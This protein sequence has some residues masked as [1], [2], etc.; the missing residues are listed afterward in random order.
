MQLA[1]ELDAEIVSVDSMQVYRGLDIGTAKPSRSDQAAVPHHMIDVADP[2]DAFTAA[3]HQRLGVP[4]IDAIE[5]RGR[6]PIVAG[7]SGLHFRALVD[8]LDFPP[9]DPAIRAEVEALA[10]TEAVLALLEV[11]PDAAR[12]VDLANPRRVARA[13]EIHRITGVTPTERST[14]EMAAAVRDYRPRLPLVA[15]GVD[16][17]DDL[18]PRVEARFDQMLD[19]GLLD[20]VE[21][22]APRLG[23][24]AAQ[25][26]GYKE[27][28][29]VVA[30]ERSL[31]D[32]REAAIRA[33]MAL[34]KR[35]RTFFRRDPR[36]EWISWHDDTGNMAAEALSLATKTIEEA[37]WIS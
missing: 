26:V 16:P 12:F 35:Q 8:P 31:E 9:A 11:D 28:L 25:G 23:A 27:L 34:A 5:K 1:E 17:G 14:S 24:T 20:E 13:L 37:A 33:T 2:E 6:V 21:L 4:A 29:P 22:L 10:P 30:G 15:I 36:I 19:G 32:G 3:H 7:G 18:G